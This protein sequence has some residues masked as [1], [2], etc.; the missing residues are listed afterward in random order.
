MLNSILINPK[1]K[2][3]AKLKKAVKDFQEYDA[4][5]KQYYS[6]SLQK[7]GELQSYVE[8]LEDTDK[9]AKKIKD[10]GEQNKNLNKK[11]AE[12][13]AVILCSNAEIPTD[14]DKCLLIKENLD[15]KEQTKT[16]MKNNAKLG[17]TNKELVNKV[18][19]LVN[20]LEKYEKVFD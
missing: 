3:I 12:L 2:E 1:D 7:L 18:C 9:C 16:L 13:K 10:L 20:R 8:E 5:R 15:L 14:L 4:K 19:E 11:I 17:K 6:E